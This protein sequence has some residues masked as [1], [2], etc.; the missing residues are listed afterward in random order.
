MLTSYIVL[1]QLRNYSC[2]KSTVILAFKCILADEII[3]VFNVGSK[4]NHSFKIFHLIIKMCYVEVL[5]VCLAFVVVI[6][7]MTRLH[8]FV[9]THKGCIILEHS[10]LK[11]KWKL[12]QLI[13][14]AYLMLPRNVGY[15]M[16]SNATCHLDLFEV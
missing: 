12:I 14:D 16:L 2:N 6:H 10:S 15:R 13:F 1:I 11:C 4:M 8:V 3:L 9:Y 7:K 5:C